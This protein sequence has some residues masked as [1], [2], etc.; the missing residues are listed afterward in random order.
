MGIHESTGSILG[1]YRGVQGLCIGVCRGYFM[2]MQGLC[3][4]DT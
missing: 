4:V 2:G 3:I 1:V